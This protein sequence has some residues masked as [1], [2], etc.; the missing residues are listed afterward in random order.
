MNPVR[1]TVRLQLHA[2]FTLHDAARQVPYY[3]ALGVSHLYLSPIWRAVPGSTHGY[4]VVDPT[5]VNPELGG[6]AA[7]RALASVARAHDMGLV[8]DIVPNHMAAHAGNRWW[9]DVLQHGRRS[10]YAHWFDIHWRAPLAQG[11]LLLP[12]LDRPLEEALDDGA[13]RI[14]ATG[15]APLLLHHDTPLPLADRGTARPDDLRGLLQAQ[16]YRPIWWRLGDDRINYRRFFTITSLAGLQVQH[17]DV[18][19]TVHRLPLSLLAE[20]LVDGLRVDHVD[21]LADPKGYLSRLRSAMDAAGSA[22]GQRPLLWVEKILAP[23]EDLP[24]TWDCDGTTGY[25]FMDQVSAWLHHPAGEAPLARHWREVSL[26]SAAFG[27]EELLAR[28]EVLEGGLRSE[29]EALL[30]LLLRVERRASPEDA[31][32]GRTALS[33][34]LSALLIRFPVYRTYATAAEAG[35]T[36]RRIWNDVLDGVQHGERADTLRA[37]HWIA[38]LFWDPPT[39]AGGGADR[40]ALRLRFQ[41]LSAPL[42]AKAVEDRAFYRHV[43]LLSRNEVGSRPDHFALSTRAMHTRASMRA[44]RHPRAMLATATHDHK[45]G[46]DSRAR[47]AV[48]SEHPLWWVRQTRVLERTAGRVGLRLPPPAVCQMLWQTLV[49]AWPATS[50]I[51]PEAFAT[52]IVQWQVKAL[53]EGDLWSSWTDPDEAFE[54]RLERFTRALLIHPA[55]APVRGVLE[56]SVAHVAAAG[57]RNALAQAVLRLTLPGVPD[58]YQGTEGWDLSLVDPDNRRPVDYA[59]RRAWLQDPRPWSRLLQQWQDGAV[60]ARLLQRLLAARRARPSLFAEGDYQPLQ[61]DREVPLLAFLR[62]HAGARLLVAVARHTGHQPARLGAALGDAHWHG[63]SLAVPRGTYRNLLTGAEL[64]SD[65]SPTRL[66]QLFN[67]SP[68]AIYSTW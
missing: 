22:R 18:F 41:Q 51:D 15:P 31:R 16:A 10:A 42:N 55:A 21:G 19:D 45:R 7:L 12:I 68:V 67:G 38:G 30:R 29:F 48:L 36:D 17:D 26:R 49:G 35:D 37:A 25:D 62:E 58:L 66:R 53:R 64:T 14:D 32:F 23:D 27:S 65:G 43:V 34:A 4:D 57:A 50:D 56:R 60:K 33:R 6:D 13:L 40:A 1:A 61:P 3:A 28:R 54:A 2:G 47:L 52:R 11:R 39:D 24:A 44:S 46:E 63:A 5:V 20:G 59:Q 9:W 8:L